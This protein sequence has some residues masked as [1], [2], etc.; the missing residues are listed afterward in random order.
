MC[1]IP[2]WIVFTIKYNIWSHALIA[3]GKNIKITFKNE[4]IFTE[5]V[6]ILAWIH[7]KIYK[8]E[9]RWYKPIGKT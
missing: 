8:I 5:I 6:N 9:F 7:N 1:Y 3:E 2:F 4:I